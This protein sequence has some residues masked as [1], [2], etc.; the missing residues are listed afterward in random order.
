M[1][2]K[3]D[4]QSIIMNR[5]FMDTLQNRAAKRFGETALAEE[6]Y[7]FAFGKLIDPDWQ[8]S[9]GQQFERKRN[10]TPQGFLFSCYNRLLEDYHRKK[11]GRPRP[12]AW[13]KRMGP[14][15]VQIHKLLCIQLLT[16]DA[17]LSRLQAEFEK[18]L[19]AIVEEAV[20][21]IRSK[22]TD[23]GADPGEVPHD[24]S[25]S[26]SSDNWTESNKIP[27]IAEKISRQTL[28]GI[29]SA[30]CTVLSR[31]TGGGLQNIEIPSSVIKEAENFSLDLVPEEKLLLRMVYQDG[32]SVVQAARRLGQK[33]HTVRRRLKKAV[34]S[35][36]SQL[37]MCGVNNEMLRDLLG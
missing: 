26:E 23:C 17:V 1:T 7:T 36:R 25:Q 28:Q 21:I 35:L 22:V 10:C 3:I 8:S 32:L 31:S 30:L 27:T 6:A 16:P 4:W 11:F 15:W 13:L 18:A 5:D 12:P 24:F 2:E 33:E 34:A 19:E 29:L 9:R 37:E 20:V 14:L